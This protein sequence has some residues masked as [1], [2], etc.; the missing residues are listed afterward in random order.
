[1]K[2][3]N[4]L[5]QALT[6]CDDRVNGLAPSLRWLGKGLSQARVAV[7]FRT[8]ETDA[9]PVTVILSSVHSNLN[10]YAEMG[11]GESDRRKEPQ[12]VLHEAHVAHVA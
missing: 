6:W 3:W 9:F 2:E 4:Q 10:H 11:I 5:P 8:T 1:M 7:C 12:Y